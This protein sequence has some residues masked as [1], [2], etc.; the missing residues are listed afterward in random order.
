MST[1]VT[2]HGSQLFTEKRC[3]INPGSCE[4]ARIRTI[5]AAGYTQENTQKWLA[6]VRGGVH[7]PVIPASEG[8]GRKIKSS[9]P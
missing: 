5:N 8:R 7:T 2:V 3:T 6:F 9:R 4:Q 1:D